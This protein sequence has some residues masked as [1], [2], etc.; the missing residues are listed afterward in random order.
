MNRAIIHEHGSYTPLSYNE[1]LPDDNW[2][3]QGIPANGDDKQYGIRSPKFHKH[4]YIRRDQIFAD[5]DADIMMVSESRPNPDG[6][7]NKVLANAT[8]R[9]RPRFYRWI[10]S[11]IGKAKEVMAAFLLEE[12]RTSAINSIKD[13]DEVDLLLLFPEWYDDTNF[14]QLADAVHDFIVNSVLTEFFSLTL[15]SKDPVTV[16]KSAMADAARQ[17]IKKLVNASKPGRI[18]KIQK[19]F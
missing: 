19:P 17:E 12:F 9:F 14:Q 7:E 8:E 18:R 5:L 2:P 4:I 1:P 15:T 13:V 3:Y 6:S 10:D 11:Y 16:D